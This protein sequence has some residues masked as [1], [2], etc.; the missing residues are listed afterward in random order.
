V[1]SVEELRSEVHFCPDCGVEEQVVTRAAVPGQVA[2]EALRASL[3][4]E[5]A[6]VDLD[7]VIAVFGCRSCAV[8]SLCGWKD[9]AGV[10]VHVHFR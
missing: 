9:G 10:T 3:V 5:L 7:V 8:L 4:G 1:S 2:L 6:D